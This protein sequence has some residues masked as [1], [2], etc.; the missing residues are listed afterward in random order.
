MHAGREC[1]KVR[2]YA[3]ERETEKEKGCNCMCACLRVFLKE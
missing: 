2:M 3:F 1:D